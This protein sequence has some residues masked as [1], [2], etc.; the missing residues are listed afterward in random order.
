MANTHDNLTEL[1]SGIAAAIRSKTGSTAKIKADNF[2]SAINA[3]EAG[4]GGIT[5]VDTITIIAN[6]NYDVTAYANAEVNVPTTG[7]DVVYGDEIEVDSL[8]QLH[9][10]NKYIPGGTTTRE[11]V[12]NQLLVYNGSSKTIE[13]EYADR[14][15]IGDDGLAL[16]S[17]GYKKVSITGSSGAAVLKGKAVRVPANA[18]HWYY[19]IPS[20]ATLSYSVSGSTA[21]L[22]VSEATHVIYNAGEDKLVG[23]VVSEDITAYPQN[24][25]QDGYK[26]VYNGTLANTGGTNTSRDIKNITIQEVQ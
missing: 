20:T 11:V 12:T 17:E 21:R 8:S 22:T 10:W 9:S 5:P 25:T 19:E 18:S 13:I 2:P 26:Y 1:F 24:G 4:S 23:I 15:V 16:S 7:G 6:G 3:I 14:V